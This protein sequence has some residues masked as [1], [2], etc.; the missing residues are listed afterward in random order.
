MN[1]YLII[2]GLGNWARIYKTNIKA[3]LLVAPSDIE[4]PVYTFNATGFTPIP[5]QKIPFPTL[6]IAS[7]NDHWVSVDRARFF[8]DH[9]GSKFISIGAA[10]HINV[11]S[12]YGKWD[13]G[14][15]LIQTLG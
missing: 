9:W 15:A 5:L 4:S 14:L 13:D 6:V 11:A 12:G 7:E 10:G 8:A 2:P 3:A 1:N